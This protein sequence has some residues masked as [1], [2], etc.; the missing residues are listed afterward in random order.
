MI[1]F[2]CRK[3]I[4]KMHEIYTKNPAMGDADSLAG[5][6]KISQSKIDKLQAELTQHEVGVLT[7]HLLHNKSMCCIR[8]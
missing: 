4:Q 1:I 8:K 2:F 5:Q 6:M 7:E 3:A